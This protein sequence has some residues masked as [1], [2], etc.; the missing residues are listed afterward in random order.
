LPFSLTQYSFSA[1]KDDFSL[2]KEH[3]LLAPPLVKS[4]LEDS[5]PSKNIFSI[6]PFDCFLVLSNL[7]DVEDLFA[8]MQTCGYN[9]SIVV[10]EQVWGVV[11]KKRGIKRLTGSGW[12]ESVKSYAEKRR[13]W[14]DLRPI[15][16]QTV[17]DMESM[18][19][20]IMGGWFMFRETLVYAP[21]VEG[22]EEMK[23]MKEFEWGIESGWSC[24]RESAPPSPLLNFVF[25]DEDRI[26]ACDGDLNLFVY[27]LETKRSRVLGQLPFIPEIIEVFGDIC[28][29][30]GISRP[31]QVYIWNIAENDGRS[32]LLAQITLEPEVVYLLFL[33]TV[34]SIFHVYPSLNLV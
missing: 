6:L 22:G 2:V 3:S 21:W 17:N 8:F 28:C 33:K 15:G 5:L 9:H 26:V 7:L 32:A 20:S 25:L 24:V 34:L 12:R 23:L 31:H 27:N 30:V 16:S 18:G 10:S 14:I 1:Q 19:A 4:Q 11:A 13:K 29:V